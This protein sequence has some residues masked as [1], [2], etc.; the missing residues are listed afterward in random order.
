VIVDLALGA[1]G[2]GSRNDAAI[3]GPA[4]IAAA[5]TATAS[6]AASTTS[7]TTASATAIGQSHAGCENNSERER[8][9]SKASNE[10]A[11]SLHDDPPRASIANVRNTPLHRFIRF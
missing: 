11:Q 4:G 5:T 9:R 10:L 3:G 1:Y 7:A 8:E 2:L 6:T